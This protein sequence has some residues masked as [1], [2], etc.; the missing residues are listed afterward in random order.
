M[1]GT[2]TLKEARENCAKIFDKMDAIIKI[3]EKEDRDLKDEEVKSYQTLEGQYKLACQDRDQLERRPSSMSIASRH[4]EQARLLAQVK[5]SVTRGQGVTRTPHNESG[6]ETLGHFLSTAAFS[7][8]DPRLNFQEFQTVQQMSD[9]P[10]GGYQVPQ[11]FINELLS[12]GPEDAVVKPR[13]R[14]LPVG[15]PPD[16]AVTMPALDQSGASPSN[17]YG[18]VSVAWG[19]ELHSKL[20]TNAMLRQITWEPKELA[21]MIPVSEKLLRNWA[22]AG[23]TLSLLLRGALTSAEDR[24]Y[25]IGSGV[26]RP[27][28]Y[29]NSDAALDVNRQTANRITLQDILSMRSRILERN[30]AR[31]AWVASTA[32]REELLSLRNISHDSPP[33]GDQSLVFQPSLREGEADRML[34]LEVTFTSEL[35]ALGSRGDLV[36]ANFQYYVVKPGAG[37]FVNFGVINDDFAKGMLRLRIIYNTDGRPWMTA[38]IVMPNGV[39]MAGCVVLDVVAG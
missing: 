33:V 10:S 21:G 31:P 35:P 17:I 26:G 32:I 1:Y 22:G 19:P 6:F 7:P 5:P 11:V 30:G 28:G 24:E 18:G 34:G 8:S 37:P 23:N 27:L 4:Q 2:L 16:S 15:S 36:L 3:A 13:A 20:E 9:G 38:P 14:V 39:S 29:T 25:L 12:V